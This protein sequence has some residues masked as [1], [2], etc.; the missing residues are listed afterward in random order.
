MLVFT[1]TRAVEFALPQLP[2][3][4]LRSS[5]LA[6]IGPATAAALRAAGLDSILQAGAGYTSE[7]LLRGLGD[8]AMRVAEA[9]IVGAEGGRKALLEG[10]QQS[11]VMVHELFVYERQPADLPE[12]NIGLLNRSQ[13]IL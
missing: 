8:S 4:L 9:F 6:A 1:S 3:E 10:L 13:R 7:D 12:R 2:R 5:K 11:G